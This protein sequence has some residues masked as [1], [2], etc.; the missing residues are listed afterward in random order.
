MKKEAARLADDAKEFLS[1]VSN[2]NK[3]TRAEKTSAPAPAKV[4]KKATKPKK[5]SNKTRTM[6]ETVKEGQKFVSAN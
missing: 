4:V 2:G 5:L 3:R 1:G 6:A